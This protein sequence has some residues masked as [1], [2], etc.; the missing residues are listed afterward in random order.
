M[1]WFRETEQLWKGQ[2][3]SLEIK[4]MLF[5]GK[6]KYQDIKIFES[7]TYGKCL[8]IDGVI[9]CT[10]RDECSYQEMLSHLP[11]STH[12]NPKHILV[13]GGGDGGIVREILKYPSVEAVHLCEIDEMV[14]NK[15]R[16]FIPSMASALDDPRVHIH[17]RDGFQFLQENTN[18]FDVLVTDSSDPVGPAES[19]YQ[20]KFFELCHA[21]LTS[22]GVYAQ[23]GE[24]MW[25]HLEMIKEYME[26]LGSK[27]HQVDYAWTSVPTYPCGTIGFLVCSKSKAHDVHVPVQNTDDIDLTF[28]SRD[29]HTAA[30]KKPR[31]VEKQLK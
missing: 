30:F 23:Q 8:V 29:M 7:T 9:Q 11:M 19:L 25:L 4:E 24:C 22:D 17:I 28:Y 3:M 20:P 16:E 10:E 5:E 26:V 2:Q 12:A 27:F 21:A 18:T 14:I 13:I 15:C 31:F 1:T 6:S